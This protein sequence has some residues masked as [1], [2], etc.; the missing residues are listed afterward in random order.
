V[1]PT[2]MIRWRSWVGLTV[3]PTA[4]CLSYDLSIRAVAAMLVVARSLNQRFGVILCIA[5]SLSSPAR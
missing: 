1:I 2:A 3:I 4:G 5:P